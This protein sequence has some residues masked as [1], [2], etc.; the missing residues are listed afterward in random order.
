MRTAGGNPS[1]S[2]SASSRRAC[3]AGSHRTSAWT[4]GKRRVGHDD[5]LTALPAPA[6]P[7]PP[8]AANGAG[9]PRPPAGRAGRAVPTCRAGVRLRSRPRRPARRP[10]WR[11]PAPPR[12]A[13]SAST[14]SRPEVRTTTPGNARP[15]S[16][17]V[18]RAPTT[19]ARS[20]CLPQTV[21]VQSTEGRPHQPQDGI[22]PA[23]PRVSGPSQNAAPCRAAAVGAGERGL[24]APPAAPGP[25]PA[26]RRPA[27]SRAACHATVGSRAAR[28][29]GSRPRSASSPTGTTRGAAA[30][31]AARGWASGAAHRDCE[32][33]APTRRSWRGRRSAGQRRSRWA[34]CT[35]TSRTCG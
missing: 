27:R 20:R 2:R 16:S 5:D 33:A 7:A 24:V 10:A 8:Q 19:P 17:A 35:R 29:P 13:R 11:R 32:R 25:A 15:S 4:A 30:R 34:R 9:S 22:A 18:R 3:Q 1:A 26:D 12:P 28:A 6:G 31:T 23:E 14:P 21:Q